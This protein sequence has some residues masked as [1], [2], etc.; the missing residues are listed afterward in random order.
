MDD[1]AGKK[2]GTQRGTTGYLYCSDDFGEDAVVAYDNRLTAV[3][4]SYTH[5]DVYKRQVVLHP[6]RAACG[7]HQPAAEQGQVADIV[8]GAAVVQHEIRLEVV[9][10]HILHLALK[11]RLI[12]VYKR[13]A[14]ISSG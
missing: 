5:L 4:V 10:H 8:V 9:E 13:Q 12:D 11:G 2:I 6:L 3:P 14:V 7:I 1:L